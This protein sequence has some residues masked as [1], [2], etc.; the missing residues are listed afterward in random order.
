MRAAGRLDEHGLLASSR[1]H[2]WTRLDVVSHLLGG[3]Q[4]LLGGLACPTDAVPDVD[5]ASYWSSWAAD[6]GAT[7]PI[8]AL[9][10]QRRRTAAYRRPAHAVA[11]LAEVAD[12][13]AR[14]VGSVADRAHAFQG[15]VLT[16]GDL[17]A[18][19][20]VE[21]AVHHLDLL[22]DE[23]PA[24]ALTLARRTV[25]AL[26]AEPTPAAWTDVDAVLIG[27][28]RLAGPP[29]HPGLPVLG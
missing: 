20:A 26:A 2:G 25:D 14:A 10:W 28:G 24:D 9:M 13:L 3:W 21:N 15:H 17:C 29:G 23:P 4:E 1:C 11:E 12:V 27:Y 7:D 5:A 8:D 22:L 16:A 6:H 19:W 18:S